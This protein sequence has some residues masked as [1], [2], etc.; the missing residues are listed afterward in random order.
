MRPSSDFQFP[1]GFRFHPS[2]EELII[3]YLR[4]RVASRPLPAS[5]IAEIDLYKYNP[6]DLPKKALFGEDEWFFFSPRDRK[7]PNGARPNR[8]AGSGYWKASG[9]DRPILTSGS[10]NIGV[11][12]ALVFYS[13]RPP[14]GIK[15]DWL[16]NEYR[17]L[18]T[19]TKPSRLK[20]SMRLDD[21]VLCR[22]R[23]KGSMSKNSSEVQDS[24]NKDLFWYLP[25]MEEACRTYT[26]YNTDMITECL[27][28]D[29]RLLASILAGQT[30]PPIDT[31][32]CVSNQESN[33]DNSLTLVY[34]EDG[35]N[36][37]NSPITVP[38]FDS[39]SPNEDARCNNFLP[40]DNQ[41]S[42]TRNE[43][44]LPRDTI[45]CTDVKYYGQNQSQD[46]F[47]NP[48]PCDQIS[49]FLELNELIQW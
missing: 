49:G 39:S 15:T 38:S 44:I 43:D 30:L 32:S 36:K 23:Q 13:G 2:D 14:K 42:S 7:Y 1:P 9:T 24:H 46:S 48:N 37:L 25:K 47:Y 31:I 19:T 41:V 21:W 27:N 34:H 26:N 35:S 22:V 12:K 6:W 40:S 45:P 4:N 17:L 29:C 10:K 18:D 11:K 5:I 20:G 8:A 3:H 16:M 33:K 28:K